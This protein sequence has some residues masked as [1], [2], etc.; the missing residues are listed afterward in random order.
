MPTAAKM[1]AVRRASST[2]AALVAA[3][4]PMAMI[5]SDIGATALARA[6]HPG[7]RGACGHRDGHACPP[8]TP[9][10]ANRIRSWLAWQSGWRADR[11]RR[12]IGPCIGGYAVPAL[13]VITDEFETVSRHLE[14][15]GCSDIP[16]S[17][18]SSLAIRLGVEWG[19]QIKDRRRFG[20]SGSGSA[21]RGG[22]RTG[23]E[24][25]RRRPVS[26]V[27]TP[28]STKASSALY[29]V[30]RLILGIAERTD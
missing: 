18:G 10:C 28:I 5:C 3:V 8:S 30:A 20:G 6:H 17:R 2:T 1:P 26:L 16:A 11:R 14:T 12:R 4:V 13:F 23:S 27:A 22:R 9:D 15:L 19:R 21:G 24:S 29:T 25:C 7:R